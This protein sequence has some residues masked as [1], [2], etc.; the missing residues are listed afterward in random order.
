MF[1]IQVVGKTSGIAVS[2]VIYNLN[3]DHE[4]YLHHVKTLKLVKW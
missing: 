1:E 2:P 3:W 4:M